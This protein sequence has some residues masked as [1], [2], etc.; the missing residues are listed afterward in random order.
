MAKR[1]YKLETAGCTDK[2]GAITALKMCLD[3][4]AEAID[5][6]ANKEIECDPNHPRYREMIEA[7]DVRGIAVFDLE[8]IQMPKFEE[9]INEQRCYT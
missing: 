7:L 1:K 3:S 5:A 6:Y 9:L 2:L 8:R 4:E